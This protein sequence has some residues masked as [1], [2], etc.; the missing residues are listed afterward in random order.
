MANSHKNKKVRVL[1]LIETADNNQ[2]LAVFPEIKEG[3]GYV[4]GYAHLGGHCKVE[5]D[6]Y[7]ELP[8]AKKRDYKGLYDELKSIGYDLEELNDDQFEPVKFTFT[9]EQVESRLIVGYKD[10]GIKII[11]PTEDSRSIVVY[12]YSEEM[13]EIRKAFKAP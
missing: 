8:Q 6:Y 11:E 9:S 5:I 13:E 4:S 10:G 2:I 7:K 12:I 3:N 1:F